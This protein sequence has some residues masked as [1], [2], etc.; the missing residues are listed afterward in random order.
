M[1]KALKKK[2]IELQVYERD[3]D[4]I[5]T[6]RLLG[7]LSPKE[8]DALFVKP[9]L[10]NKITTVETASIKSIGEIDIIEGFRI[11][12]I[13]KKRNDEIVQDKLLFISEPLEYLSALNS[14]TEASFVGVD[15]YFIATEVD[16]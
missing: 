9:E 4:I 14:D 12:M 5:Y 1:V 2:Q 11:A 16:V 10:K 13:I 7:L 8:Y 3:I 6:G 15:S